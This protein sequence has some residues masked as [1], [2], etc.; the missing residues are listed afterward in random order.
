MFRLDANSSQGNNTSSQNQLEGA[1]SYAKTVLT[2]WPRQRF[3]LLPNVADCDGTPGNGKIGFHQ[4]R[5]LDTT[6][7]GHQ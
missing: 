4:N 6:Q 2:S 1:G 3:E 5:D 7:I